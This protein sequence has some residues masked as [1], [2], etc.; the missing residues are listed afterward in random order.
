MQG[1]ASYLLKNRH[2]ELRGRVVIAG[3]SFPTASAMRDFAT[4]VG[5]LWENEPYWLADEALQVPREAGMHAEYRQ[6]S[7]C[8]GVYRIEQD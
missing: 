3:I 4:S 1:G 5:D 8:A 7:A 6:V 2:L